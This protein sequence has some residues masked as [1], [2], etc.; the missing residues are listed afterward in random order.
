MRMIKVS[1]ER[2]QVQGAGYCFYDSRYEKYF[3]ETF[4]K[5]Q[6]IAP[7]IGDT[8]LV[9]TKLP[10]QALI[11]TD[12]F[13]KQLYNFYDKELPKLFTQAGLKFKKVVIQTLVQGKP[14]KSTAWE[15]KT[16]VQK[17]KETPMIA[18]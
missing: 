10:E 4:H 9:N 3:M 18:F 1:P 8:L 14:V 13:E 7:Q 2:T 12:F 5:K 15:I 6:I 11:K 17:F 16:G